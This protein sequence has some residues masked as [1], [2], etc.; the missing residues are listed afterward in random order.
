MKALR[1]N[2]ISTKET[3][4]EKQ[5]FPLARPS[6][7]WQEYGQHKAVFHLLT[8]PHFNIQ[9]ELKAFPHAQDG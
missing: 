9:R 1:K 6:P 5:P 2:L 7:N 4:N 3:A 8:A